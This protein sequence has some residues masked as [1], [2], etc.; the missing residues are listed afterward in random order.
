[1]DHEAVHW[2][3]MTDIW[4]EWAGMRDLIAA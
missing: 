4:R 3:C 2:Q 1:V